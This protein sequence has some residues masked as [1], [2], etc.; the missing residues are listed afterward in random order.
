MNTNSQRCDYIEVLNSYL[1]EAASEE[2]EYDVNAIRIRLNFVTQL[3]DEQFL[4]NKEYLLNTHPALLCKGILGRLLPNIPGTTVTAG[5]C[6]TTRTEALKHLLESDLQVTGYPLYPEKKGIVSEVIPENEF[7]TN[8]FGE[9]AVIRVGN[10]NIGEIEK[11]DPDFFKPNPEADLRLEQYLTE[12]EETWV[13]TFLMGE[14]GNNCVGTYAHLIKEMRDVVTKHLS[15]DEVSHLSSIPALLVGISEPRTEREICQRGLPDLNSI[16]TDPRGGEG[17]AFLD[18]EASLDQGI[19]KTITEAFGCRPD[20]LGVQPTAD[21]GV[22]ISHVQLNSLKHHPAIVNE[23]YRSKAFYHVMPA[24]HAEKLM[25]NLQVML[26]LMDEYDDPDYQESVKAE[27]KR[28]RY[29]AEGSIK[30]HYD[31]DTKWVD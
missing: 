5:S 2:T 26:N 21:S 12:E 24:E 25:K 9:R 19:L 23:Q 4:L 8:A 3:T 13:R 16:L 27:I 6:L 1:K 20:V 29:I 28:L 31:V 18:S 15:G 11:R 30:S 17:L 14:F 10:R 7:P 22:P